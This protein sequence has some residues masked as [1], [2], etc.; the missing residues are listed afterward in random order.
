[1]PRAA[2]DGRAIK[3]DE[4]ARVISWTKRDGI[5]GCTDVMPRAEAEELATSLREA[6]PDWMHFDV[7]DAT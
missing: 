7:E 3:E 6:N 1:M 4:M 2:H 5:V